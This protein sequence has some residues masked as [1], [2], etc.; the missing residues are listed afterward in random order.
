MGPRERA[1][2]GAPEDDKRG[3]QL[4][5]NCVHP[6]PMIRAATEHDADL[7]AHWLSDHEIT[8]YLTSNLRGGTLSAQL[9]KLA[10]RRKDQGWFVF[11]RDD[12]PQG[13]PAGLVAVDSIDAG[14]GIG[15]LWFVLGDKSLGGQGLTSRA[16]DELCTQNPLRLHVASAWVAEVNVPSLRC[17]A[18]AGFAEIGR[19]E[20]AVA[21]PGTR[22]ARVLFARK[23]ARE[24]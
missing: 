8:R 20:G 22:A 21:L 7:I 11:T 17:L 2:G 6:A 10:L 13:A 5:M 1:Q 3:R 12:D 4:R 15:N 24:A 9:I 14:D 18:R 16:I 19:I 23:L